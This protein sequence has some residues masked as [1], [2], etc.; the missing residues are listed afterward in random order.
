MVARKRTDLE[1]GIEKVA[2]RVVPFLVWHNKHPS[3]TPDSSIAEGFREIHT[4][5]AHLVEDIYL[6][7]V[8]ENEAHWV[9]Q[10]T[11]AADVRADPQPPFDPSAPVQTQI[12]FDDG[13]FNGAT[14]WPATPEQAWGRFDAL[15]AYF[16]DVVEHLSIPAY[17]N[18]PAPPVKDAWGDVEWIMRQIP[19]FAG[20]RSIVRVIDEGETQGDLLGEMGARV[21][22]VCKT[23]AAQPGWYFCQ[24]TL[25]ARN[26]RNQL[27]AIQASSPSSV[28]DALMRF[29]SC[30]A[31]A[32]CGMAMI[33]TA[34]SGVAPE[35]TDPTPEAPPA[36]VL[37]R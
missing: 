2:A 34:Q 18:P 1:G 15:C 22:V 14:R 29:S 37:R 8:T 17:N 3:E 25:N 13:L 16:G 24:I 10:I 21:C 28:H 33:E 30:A 31:A 32:M 27:S 6:E 11:E 12:V 23:D 7:L 19:G 36:A 9:F 4:A 35:A 26:P 5:Q 20:P